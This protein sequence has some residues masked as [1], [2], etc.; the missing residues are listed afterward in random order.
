[1]ILGISKVIP[2]SGSA[3][4]VI[5]SMNGRSAFEMPLMTSVSWRVGTRPALSVVS[6]AAATYIFDSSLPSEART[7][8]SR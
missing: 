4:R 7:E 3:P 5:E 6:A 2:A 1:M 8:C